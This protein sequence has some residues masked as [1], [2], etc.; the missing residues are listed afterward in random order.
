MSDLDMDL[1]S[2]IAAFEA[3]EFATARQLLH[4]LA[5]QGNA[6]AQYRV[7]IMAQV[8]LGMVKNCDCFAH[9]AMFSALQELAAKNY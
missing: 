5:E 1:T 6:H 4:P 8:G 7:A 9:A 3:K 2:G